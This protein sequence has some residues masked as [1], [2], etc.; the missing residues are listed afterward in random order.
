[1]KIFLLLF[2][3]VREAFFD[4]KE[5]ADIRSSKFSVMRSVLFAYFVL[6]MCANEWFVRR[7]YVIHNR[8]RT[9]TAELAT[10]RAV[11]TTLENELCAYKNNCLPKSSS[12]N[13]SQNP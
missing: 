4:S 6:A 8:A 3:F 9:V 12:K 13:S 7:L 5:Q 2:S 1:M 11:G 10:V